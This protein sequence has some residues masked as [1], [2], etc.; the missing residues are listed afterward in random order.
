[1]KKVEYRKKNEPR[2]KHSIEGDIETETRNKLSGKGIKRRTGVEE[3][4]YF[5][6]N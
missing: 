2:W 3:K 5:V 6:M 4:M 1:M